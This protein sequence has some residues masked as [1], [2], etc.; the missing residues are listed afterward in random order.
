MTL[1][2]NSRSIRNSFGKGAL[3]FA[4]LA[5]MLSTTPHAAHAYPVNGVYNEDVRCDT[6]PNTS[7]GHEIGETTAFPID[8]RI[9]V[10]VS[11]ASSYACV[12][13]DGAP[14]DFVVQMTNLSSYSYVDLYFVA[15]V[16]ITIGNADGNVI[17]VVNAPGVISDAFKIDGTV[18]VTGI[19]DNLLGESG[20]I[21]EVFAPG[22][23]WRFIVTNVIFPASVPPTLVFDS[24]GGFAGSSAGYP[25]STASILATQLPIP[26][27]ATALLVGLGLTGM[28][29]A[30][31]RTA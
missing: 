1:S 15:D 31:R 3:A 7:M 20:G 8:E 27:P 9:Q 17:D 25:P 14:N 28:A 24:V 30:R 10:F 29:I 12:G 18:T 5:P 11:A 2:T 21:D 22:E 23:T 19:N 4:T 16:G 6:L 13:D 26:E